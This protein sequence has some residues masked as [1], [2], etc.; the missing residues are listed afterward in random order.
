MKE[1]KSKNLDWHD[2]PQFIVRPRLPQFP[3]IF[4]IPAD[5]C[6]ASHTPHDH[7]HEH[8]HDHLY[9][10]HIR[11]GF[12]FP[13]Q[14]LAGIQEL[15]PLV[16]MMVKVEHRVDCNP[17]F[18]ARGKGSEGICLKIAGQDVHWTPDDT[19][20]KKATTLF[21]KTGRKI[22]N[23]YY[24][25]GFS[26]S[27]VSERKTFRYSREELLRS[28]G[29]GLVAD[30]HFQATWKEPVEKEIEPYEVIIYLGDDFTDYHTFFKLPVV[31]PIG[32]F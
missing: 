6:I 10:M 14:N 18:V 28:I 11:Y 9:H 27:D 1:K 31:V 32:A 12:E 29:N 16:A 2:K 26:T 23:G 21:A 22:T 4:D 13:K 19:V 30:Q 8:L 17:I 15:A 3:G 25:A 7:I 5:T 24:F 20:G